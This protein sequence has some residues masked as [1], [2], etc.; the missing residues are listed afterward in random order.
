MKNLTVPKLREL[1]PSLASSPEHQAQLAEMLAQCFN[2]LNV[3]GKDA[4]QL[5]DTVKLFQFVLG[6]FPAADI[7]PAFKVFL[8]RNSRMP[9]P[10]DIVAILKRGNK[11]P[12]DQA[13]YI[14]LSKRKFESRTADEDAYIAEYEKDAI[15]LK[16]PIAENARQDI[17]MEE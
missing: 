9:A 6:D 11:P 15:G 16:N 14:A 10:S 1:T 3:Y 2:G 5:C 7:A 4:T 8:T 12:L 13:V 17:G